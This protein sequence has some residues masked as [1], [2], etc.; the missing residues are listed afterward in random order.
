MRLLRDSLVSV[1]QT[2]AAIMVIIGAS[3]TWNLGP[4]VIMSMLKA[5][6]YQV[7]DG[8]R[9][10][11]NTQDILS[12]S[13]AK[14][15]AIVRLH[16]LDN[17][18]FCSGTVISDRYV[19]SASHC[20]VNV[21]GK[22]RDEKLYIVSQDRMNV[23][24]AIPVAVESMTDLALIEGDFRTFNKMKVLV[25]PGDLNLN[26]NF[27]TC[28]YALG[29]PQITCYPINIKGNQYFSLLGDSILFKGMSGGNL[30]D[31]DKNL[32]VAINTAVTEN[33]TI[34]SPIVGLFTLFQVPIQ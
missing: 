9:T 17:R 24:E 25:D 12:N 15:N 29:S 2:M 33:G 19:L 16:T 4:D 22:M 6:N 14:S 20:L 34:F 30:F 8:I 32:I 5:S 21:L 28:G 27:K 10:P 31:L 3:I 7:K 1:G 26:D 18:F 11:F 23:Q 13:S